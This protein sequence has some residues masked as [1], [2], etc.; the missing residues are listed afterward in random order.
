[1]GARS[2]AIPRAELCSLVGAGTFPPQRLHAFRRLVR[3]PAATMLRGGRR[4]TKA[5][6]RTTLL[7]V[8]LVAAVLYLLKTPI[9]QVYWSGEHASRGPGVRGVVAC[10]P[11][12]MRIA[13]AGVKGGEGGGR[14][15]PAS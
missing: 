9:E 10:R 3:L 2:A 15:T 7:W 4:R 12:P 8:L 14:P 13:W 6:A 5:E 1:M 11:S